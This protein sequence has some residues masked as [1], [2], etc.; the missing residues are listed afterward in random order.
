[1]TNPAVKAGR[2]RYIF[3]S[4]G[5]TTTV[6]RHHRHLFVIRTA[7]RDSRPPVDVVERP[8]QRQAEEQVVVSA[9]VVHAPG[10]QFARA[11]AD[12][13]GAGVELPPEEAGVLR[14]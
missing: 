3:A 12:L 11:G 6:I 4:R 14:A 8:D 9:R 2:W 7:P 10:E 13:V 5:R 1:M